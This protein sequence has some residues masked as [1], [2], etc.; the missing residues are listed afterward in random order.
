MTSIRRSWLISYNDS[1]DSLKP[2]GSDLRD[3]EQDKALSEIL[4]KSMSRSDTSA[5]VIQIN[6][7]LIF[8][9]LFSFYS[10]N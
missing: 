8:I 7:R 4:S 1:F 3:P 5:N 2:S 9:K 6:H 10:N